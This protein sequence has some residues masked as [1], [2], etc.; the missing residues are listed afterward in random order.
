MTYACGYALVNSGRHC[1]NDEDECYV[2]HETPLE[3]VDK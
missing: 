3:G 2:C 1:L